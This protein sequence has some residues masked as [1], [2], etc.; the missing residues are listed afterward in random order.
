MTRGRVLAD[1]GAPL[2]AVR[3]LARGG[4]L[5]DTAATASTQVQ[6]ELRRQVFEMAWPLV[7]QN[8]TRPLERRRG[9]CP[10]IRSVRDL[11]PVCHDGFLDD[12]FAVVDYVLAYAKSP[13][14]NLEGW[15]CT[16]IAAAVVD[17]HR[18]RRGRLG[19][20]QRPRVPT[21]LATGLDGDP[22]LVELARRILEWV[23]VSA[24][25]GTQTWPIESWAEARSAVTGEWQRTG[26]RRAVVDDVERVCATMRRLRPAWYERYVEHPLQT[27]QDL[28][29]RLC[30]DTQLVS[31]ATPPDDDRRLIELAAAALDLIAR[32]TDAGADVADVIPAAL[33]QIFL[34]W[35]LLADD[36]LLDASD[37]DVVIAT[38]LDDL[39]ISARITETVVDILSLPGATIASGC[40]ARRRVA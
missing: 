18:R 29:L 12:V 25:A 35:D 22:W 23:G 10:C 38:A 9:H 3:D 4:R 33:Q 2:S 36:H 34:N 16:R 8:H 27:K 1:P 32:R 7:F 5:A 21:W 6:T 15:V 24:D 40:I 39:T 17:G 28:T 11:A 14:D 30:S 19:A 20:Q 26:E 37:N 13:I 31:V